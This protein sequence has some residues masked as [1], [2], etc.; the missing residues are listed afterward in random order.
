MNLRDA[1]LYLRDRKL[2]LRDRKIDLRV[3]F[4]MK[5][6]KGLLKLTNVSELGF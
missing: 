6:V 2:D 5:E 1:K 4:V 3:S